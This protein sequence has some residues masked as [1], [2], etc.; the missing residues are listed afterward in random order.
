M[1]VK[2][3]FARKGKR[4]RPVQ[5]LGDAPRLGKKKAVVPVS[6]LKVLHLHAGTGNKKDSH[7]G[8]KIPQYISAEAVVFHNAGHPSVIPVISGY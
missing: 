4:G 6:D 5:S 3:V 2:D 8:R 1:R 7:G